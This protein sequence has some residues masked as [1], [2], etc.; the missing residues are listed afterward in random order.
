MALSNYLAQSVICGLVFF[1]VGLG[2]YGQF[3]GYWLYLVVLGVWV[4][5]LAWSPWWLARY[6]QDSAEWL[7]RRL[8]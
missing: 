4:L 2:L 5:L 7:W 6:R 8:T 1:T 3:T